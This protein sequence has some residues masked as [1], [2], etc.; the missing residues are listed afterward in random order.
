MSIAELYQHILR[1]SYIAHL[2]SHAHQSVPS[3]LSPLDYGWREENNK[4]TFKWFDGDQV[5]PT[6]SGVTII[7]ENPIGT[8]L[9]T[10]FHNTLILN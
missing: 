2:W 3:E 8:F 6:I 4:Y 10:Y 5:P 7:D 1:T 9:L